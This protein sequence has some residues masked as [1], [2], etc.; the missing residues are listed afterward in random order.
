MINY[1]KD[2]KWGETAKKL[3]SNKEGVD[4]VIEVGGPATMTQS[5][6]AI[7]REGVITI[8]GFL[9]GY[10][11][12]DQPSTLDALTSCCIIRGVLIGS[13]VQLQSMNR[14][15]EAHNIH[16]VVDSKAFGFD[17]VK[18]AYQ[19]QWDQKNFG[20]VVIQWEDSER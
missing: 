17:N 12:E 19:Y 4:H 2:P 15:I 6:K 1:N 16:P 20:K 9:G 3:C 10:T 7:K 14:A 8:I 18:D 13:R 11:A 5:L